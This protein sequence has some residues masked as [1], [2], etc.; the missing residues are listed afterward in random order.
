MLLPLK[1][2]MGAVVGACSTYLYKDESARTWV[3]DTGSKLKSGVTGLFSRKKTVDSSD[4]V[5]QQESV[6]EAATVA[7][8]DVV[9]GAAK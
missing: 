3:Q 5:V 6:V 2:V 1:F 7:V 4:E 8:D 9:V